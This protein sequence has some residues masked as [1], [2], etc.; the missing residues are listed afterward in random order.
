MKSTN[1]NVDSNQL[2]KVAKAILSG[3]TRIVEGCR[4]LRPLLMDAKLDMEEGLRIIAGVV[5]ESDH[6]PLKDIRALWS[7]EAW[8]EKAKELEAVENHYRA[9]VIKACQILLERLDSKSV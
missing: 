3:H 4:L 8:K 9:A 6:L 5:S 2:R 1:Q 7:E